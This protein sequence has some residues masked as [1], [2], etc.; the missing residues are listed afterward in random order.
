MLDINRI[1]ENPQKVKELLQRKLW[2][3]DFD[4][5]LSW[6][7]RKKDLI[8]I[9]EGNKAKMNQLSASV[10]QAKKNGEDISK[11]FAEVKSIAKINFYKYFFFF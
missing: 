7:Q 2:E 8:Q 1:R 10:P 11:I 6:D 3:T 4:E 5:L 9:V